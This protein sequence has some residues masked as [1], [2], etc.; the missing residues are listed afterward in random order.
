MTNREIAIQF[1]ERFCAGRIDELTELLVQNLKFRGPLYQFDHRADYLACLR[2]DA[3]EQAGLKILSVTENEDS[4]CIFYEYRKS[5]DNILI[6][7]LFQFH[8]QQ[9]TEIH[10]VFDTHQFHG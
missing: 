5:A 1:L 6:A 3:P 8:Q 7:Q 9:I 4:V 2:D 10:L